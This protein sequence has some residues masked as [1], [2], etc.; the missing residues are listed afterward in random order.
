MCSVSDDRPPDQ[1][2]VLDQPTG[3][4]AFDASAPGVPGDGPTERL[5]KTLAFAADDYTLDDDARAE[6]MVV[7]SLFFID[8]AAS[9]VRVVGRGGDGPTTR[10]RDLLARQRTTATM[11]YLLRLGVPKSAIL[12]M[13]LGSQSGPPVGS[14]DQ[15]EGVDVRLYTWPR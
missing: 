2:P 13:A 3:P 5:C 14:R 6:L 15:V 10:A 1:D 11:G 9:R 8:A 7:A 4:L 12:A